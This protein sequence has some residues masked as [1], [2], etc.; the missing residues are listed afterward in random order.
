MLLQVNFTFTEGKNVALL[1][2]LKCSHPH[3]IIYDNY[4]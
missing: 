1:E 4:D 2:T 3:Q